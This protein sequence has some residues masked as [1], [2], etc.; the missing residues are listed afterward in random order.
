MKRVAAWL[1]PPQFPAA[2]ADGPAV[3]VEREGG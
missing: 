2:M 1:E 3:C